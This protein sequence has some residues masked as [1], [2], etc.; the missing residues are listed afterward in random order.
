M[1]SNHTTTLL[2]LNCSHMPEVLWLPSRNCIILRWFWHIAISRLYHNLWYI[3]II[4]LIIQ[5]QMIYHITDF[6][7]PPFYIMTLNTVSCMYPA[8]WTETSLI[9]FQPEQETDTLKAVTIPIPLTKCE[10]CIHA[11]RKI[12]IFSSIFKYSN[13]IFSYFLS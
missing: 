4:L 11:K 10:I 13:P 9:Q 7:F 8:S 1:V 6:P 5:L 12:W 2:H 3:D